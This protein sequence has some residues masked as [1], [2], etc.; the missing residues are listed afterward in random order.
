MDYEKVRCFK[1]KRDTRALSVQ[2]FSDR[3]NITWEA[4]KWEKFLKRQ[5]LQNNLLVMVINIIG[6]KYSF[7]C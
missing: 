7:Q 4:G 2:I 3:K 1:D 6:V 5:V